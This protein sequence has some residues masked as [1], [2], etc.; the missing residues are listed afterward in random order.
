MVACY[1][2]YDFF[3][4]TSQ[5]HIQ[6]VKLVAILDSWQICAGVWHSSCNYQDHLFSWKIKLIWFIDLLE[7]CSFGKVW[8]EK[9]ELF[10]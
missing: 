3:D 1:N 10:S 4:S 5:Q 9:G 8:P 6:Y 7:L 2:L